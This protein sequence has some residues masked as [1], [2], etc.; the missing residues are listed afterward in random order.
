MKLQ[1]NRKQHRKG[2][3][4]DGQPVRG[5]G[6]RIGQPCIFKQRGHTLEEHHHAS[7]SKGDTHYSIITHH[8][9][10]SCIFKLRGHAL[11]EHGKEEGSHG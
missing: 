2:H 4:K 11:E 9:A 5:R 10:H 3:Y 6:R 7:L 1:V 8:H